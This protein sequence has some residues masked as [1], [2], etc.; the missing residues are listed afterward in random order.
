MSERKGIEIDYCP[1]CRGVWLDRGELDK[2]IQQADR[3]DQPNSA[4]SNH[5][6]ERSRG[7]PTPPLDRNGDDYGKYDDRRREYRDL[8]DDDKNYHRYG[9][10]KESFWSNLFDFD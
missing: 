6:A 10:K 3:Q 4:G 9:K 8:S 5:T 2:F 1:S 7:T